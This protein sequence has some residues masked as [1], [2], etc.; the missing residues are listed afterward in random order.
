MCT[1][2]I[3]TTCIPKRRVFWDMFVL[4]ND[5]LR[6]GRYNAPQAKNYGCW[7]PEDDTPTER[8]HLS[9]PHSNDGTGCTLHVGFC[10]RQETFSDLRIPKWKIKYQVK[11]SQV[12]SEAVASLLIA[13][14]LVGGGGE[15]INHAVTQSSWS[16]LLV[17]STYTSSPFIKISG[18]CPK[19][20]PHQVQ[21]IITWCSRRYSDPV[22]LIPGHCPLPNVRQ[23]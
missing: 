9:F 2:S 3:G 17:R 5:P 13:T 1:S 11:L 16:S 12:Q 14:W 18:E 19:W 15:W 20:T 7:W 21:N 10:K 22:W 23:S 8:C 4:W 6:H